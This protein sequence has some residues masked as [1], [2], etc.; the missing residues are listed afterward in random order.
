MNMTD[1]NLSPGQLT[2]SLP[3]IY[4]L[5]FFMLGFTKKKNFK[6]VGIFTAKVT[7]F[8]FFTADHK[9]VKLKN[10]FQTLKKKLYKLKQQIFLKHFF[11]PLRKKKLG[12]FFFP[13][14]P[15]RAK[16]NATKIDDR[17]SSVKTDEILV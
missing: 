5:S 10:Y 17:S 16:G 6:S 12:N 9:I 15:E 3:Y 1:N 4:S 2:G 11:Y 14:V 7:I 8:F 13:L